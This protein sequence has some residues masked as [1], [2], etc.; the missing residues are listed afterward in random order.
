MLFRYTAV[1]HCR[2]FLYLSV[3]HLGNERLVLFFKVMHVVTLSS[4]E[5]VFDPLGFSA[6][7]II[8]AAQILGEF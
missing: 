6:P 5:E 7:S 8:P 1:G 3:R 4:R 2:L